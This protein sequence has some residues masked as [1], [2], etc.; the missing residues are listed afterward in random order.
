MP[1]TPARETSPAGKIITASSFANASIIRPRCPLLVPLPN[2]S[3]GKN[4]SFRD[5]YSAIAHWRR[6]AHRAY[7]ANQAQ[8]G[9]T[10]K[11]AKRV[12]SHNDYGRAPA[13]C[14]LTMTDMAINRQL[15]KDRIDEI[16][17][18]EK[19]ILLKTG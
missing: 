1:C 19:S 18:I 4:T 9:E 13:Y 10:I 16:E 17:I 11:A 15:F 14:E 7:A 3:T 8:Q 5:Q 12:I 2:T 6:P